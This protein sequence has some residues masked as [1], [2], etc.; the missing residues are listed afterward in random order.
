MEKQP[1]KFTVKI[2]ELGKAAKT[3][4][5][6]DAGKILVPSHAAPEVFA[7]VIP[8]AMLSRALNLHPLDI[9]CHSQAHQK[10]QI[11]SCEMH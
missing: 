8:D 1:R 4:D 3:E 2:Q 7:K 10:A 9:C 6:A 11:L 5:H